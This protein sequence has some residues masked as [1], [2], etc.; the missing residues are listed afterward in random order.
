MPVA[1]FFLPRGS[2]PDEAIGSMLV[3]ISH[4]YARALYPE[5]D[6]LPMD[7]VRTWVTLVD[8]PHWC[9]AGQLASEGGAT[10]PY[11]E[12]LIL[13]GRPIEA[14][15]RLIAGFTDILARHLGCDP[16]LV[17]G[18]VVPIEADNWGI[19][20]VPA[21]LARRAEV[22]ARARAMNSDKSIA[23]PGGTTNLSVSQ[24]LNGG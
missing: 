9:L 12:C 10:T 4:F 18:R 13:I 5:A 1:R 6:P 3:E 8:A 24:D 11:F 20:G 14:H 15:H 22:E 21:S 19:G 17:R 16:K 2:F 23:L 7:R